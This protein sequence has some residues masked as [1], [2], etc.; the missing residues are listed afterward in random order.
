VG[1]YEPVSYIKLGPY[2]SLQEGAVRPAFPTKITARFV[3]GEAEGVPDTNNLVNV[4][5]EAHSASNYAKLKAQL[6]ADELQ[7]HGFYK[8]DGGRTEADFINGHAFNRHGNNLNVTSN[9]NRTQFDPN[10]DV[11]KLRIDTIL[12]YDRAYSDIQTRA[13]VYEKTYDFDI[14]AVIDD[15]KVAPTSNSSNVHKVFISPD[16]ELSTQFPLAPRHI[17]GK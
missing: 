3:I 6:R 11:E 15:I 16:P 17:K 4:A 1:L 14:S 5:T 7:S 13:T 10:I 8:Q 2:S 12:N 9:Q